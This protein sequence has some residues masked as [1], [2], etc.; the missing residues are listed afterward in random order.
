MGIPL[1]FKTLSE[2]YPEI[3]V[4]NIDTERSGFLFLDLNCAIHPCCRKVIAENYNSM[5]KDIY[6]MKMI[7]SII[8]YIKKLVSI[9]EPQLVYIAIDGVAPKAK[10]NQQRCRRFKSVLDKKLNQDIRNKLFKD[11]AVAEESWDTNAISPGTIFMEKLNESIREFITSFG[12]IKYIFNSSNIPGEGEHKIMNFIKENKKT[13]NCDGNIIIYGLDADLIML[14]MTCRMDNIYLL[15]EE[16]EFKKKGSGTRDSFGDSFL[17]LSIDTLKRRL[18]ETICMKYLEIDPLAIIKDSGNT[19]PESIKTGNFIDDYIVICFI[20]GNDFIPHTPAISLRNNSMDFLLQHYIKAKHN[21]DEHLVMNG[22]LN[23][24]FLIYFFNLLAEKEN[25]ILKDISNRR[26]KF[27]IKRFHFEN[28]YEKEL[29]LLNNYPMLHQETEK[30]IDIGTHGWQRRF[31]SKCLDTCDFDEVYTISGEYFKIFKWCF[32]YYF[33]K[34]PSFYYSYDYRSAPSLHSLSKYIRNESDEYLFNINNIKF[35]K[36]TVYS[37]LVQLMYILP[38]ES[39]HLLPG[40]AKNLVSTKSSDIRH[41]YPNEYEID[42]LYKRYFWQCTPILPP[43][44]L[45][46]LKKVVTEKCKIS[47]KDKKRFTKDKLFISN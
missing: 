7:V 2:D 31:Y 29:E 36:G 38:I 32:D 42:H 11:E 13:L 45:T 14:S 35:H 47:M 43:I 27:N 46:F 16:V 8:E 28:D 20:L 21:L 4:K 19:S 40:N 24:P 44:D 15:R 17:Y 26:K 37:P 33:D 12:D 9:V 41:Y 1:Y 18:N 6:E 5:Q 25:S 23:N 10:M 22:K 3:I 34:C 30:I 39:V